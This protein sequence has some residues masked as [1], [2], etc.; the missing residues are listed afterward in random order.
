GPAVAA[1]AVAAPAVAGPAVAAPAVAIGRHLLRLSDLVLV[2]LGPVDGRS[3]IRLLGQLGVG[4]G[5]GDGPG[6]VDQALPLRPVVR[7]GK[8]SSAGLT[9][10]LVSAAP[11]LTTKGS[12]AGVVSVG[13][14]L[15]VLPAETT[16]TMPAFHAA[17]T[18][19]AS[20][21][22]A[23]PA[24]PSAPKDRLITRMFMP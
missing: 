7:G 2:P 13:L 5:G 3:H 8:V 4:R 19:T 21:S 1:P 14:T 11:T 10:P 15:P 16:T 6:H 12:M 18:P 23:Y 9:V 20:G 22:L 17:S 24:E